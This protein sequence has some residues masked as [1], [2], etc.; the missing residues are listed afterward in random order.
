MQIL[1]VFVLFSPWTTVVCCSYSPGGVALG[2]TALVLATAAKQSLKA[3]ARREASSSFEPRLKFLIYVNELTVFPLACLLCATFFALFGRNGLLVP[4]M[5]VWSVVP[6]P[7]K[8]WQN[9]SLRSTI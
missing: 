1:P 9:I 4:V 7:K 2:A 3:A 8:P 5:K 6:S